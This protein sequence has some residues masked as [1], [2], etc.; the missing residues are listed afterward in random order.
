MK[1]DEQLMLEYQAGSPSAF[2]DARGMSQ[3]LTTWKVEDFSEDQSKR[4]LAELRSQ[5]RSKQFPFR[6]GLAWWTRRRVWTYGLSAGF[7]ALVLIAVVVVPSFQTGFDSYEMPSVG[8]TLRSPSVVPV[9]EQSGEQVQL[10]QIQ[11]GFELDRSAQAPT[12]A[13]SG[14]MIIRSARLIIVT[15]DFDGA[16]ERI[17]AIV[18]QSQGYLDQLT[19][20]G[21]VG[22]GRTL[23]ATLRLPSDRIEGGLSELRKIGRVR[24]ETQN[25]SDVTSQYVDLQAR[26]DN[27]RNT[28]QRLLT[29]LRERTGKLP[30]VVEAERE[31]S[32]VREQIERM[33]AQQKD[34][35]NKVQFATIQFEVSEEYRAEIDSAIPSAGTRLRNALIDGYHGALESILKTALAVLLYGPVLLVWSAMLLPVALLA[36]RVLIRSR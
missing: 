33:Q 29:L 19:A 7:A 36:R 18:R 31:I 14:P 25:S 34:M 13:P 15:K 2:A 9:P 30:E 26:L 21:E 16:R 35:N 11:Q 5:A 32:R 1:S 20:R 28:E 17:E 4:V 22:S 24:E 12:E 27:A 10:A 8:G 6:Q 3:Q 23:S